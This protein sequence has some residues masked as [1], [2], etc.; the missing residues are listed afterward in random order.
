MQACHRHGEPRAERIQSLLGN[1][2][3]HD[4][5]VLE[6]VLR[7]YVAHTLLGQLLDVVRSR[8]AAENHRFLNEFDGQSRDPA[9][10]PLVNAFCEKFV[11]A[12]R[13]R[14]HHG[15]TRKRF[16]LLA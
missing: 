14:T 4:D 16:G 8:S 13:N 11:E 9:A 6:R 5:G 12:L 15:Y 1:T 10:G 3:R 7:E 2:L